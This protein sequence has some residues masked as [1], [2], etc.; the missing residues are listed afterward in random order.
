M[1][2]TR[3]LQRNLTYYWRTNLAVLFGVA[4]A[5]AVLAGALLVGDSVRASLRDIFLERLGKTDHIVTASGFFREKLTDELQAH[6]GFSSGGFT[7]VC[8]LVALEG[9]VTHQDSGRRAARIQ[10][11]GVDE[12]FWKFHQ[13]GATPPPRDREI[14]PSTALAQELG[15]KAGDGLLLRVE[16]PSAIP[17]E[18]LHGRKEDTGRT[19][20]LN[21]REAL[22]A[23]ALGE[24]SLRPQQAAVRAV[25]V[26]LKLLQRELEQENKVNTILVAEIAPADAG[27]SQ[28]ASSAKSV[29]QL[30]RILKDKISLED[31]GIKL[32]V[33]DEQRSISLENES[34]L[35][36][37]S[38]AEAARETAAEMGLRTQPVLTYLANSIRSGEREIPDSL[39]T[40]FD[41]E[42]LARL[43]DERAAAAGRRG[44]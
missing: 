22:P 33:L 10:V 37:D 23:S 11:Y 16:K 39:V 4:A 24:F 2:I 31:M 3:L 36:N 40:A 17:V 42:N 28:G 44:G 13:K 35:L 6:E 1:R 5:V 34:A 8:P 41:D 15:A 21:V 32:R 14:L 29:L 12:R 26:P 19:I 9:T 30:E 25:F 20:R 43:Q 27:Q 18:S 38:L 7:N